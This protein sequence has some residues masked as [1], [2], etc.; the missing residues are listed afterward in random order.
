MRQTIKPLIEPYQKEYILNL[1]DKV[2][3]MIERGN[4]HSFSI[5][6]EEGQLKGYVRHSPKGNMRC[7]EDRDLTDPKV[8]ERY[9]RLARNSR[10]AS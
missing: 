5:A 4:L 1:L 3:D 7:V 6:Y 10:N 2:C 8:V 9:N